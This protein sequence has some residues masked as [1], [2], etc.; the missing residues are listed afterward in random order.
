[1]S[2]DI[3]VSGI[4][5]E[6]GAT[7]RFGTGDFSKRTLVVTVADG[8]DGKY[9]QHIP[10]EFIKDAGAKLDGIAVGQQVTVAVN[11]RGREGSGRYWLSLAGW[12]I[13]AG[14]RGAAPV[15]ATNGAEPDDLDVLPF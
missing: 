1:M 3:K 7:E 5:K 8:K 13:E 10:I 11:L 15:A 2:E 6:V 14:E 9:D 4:V 12:R